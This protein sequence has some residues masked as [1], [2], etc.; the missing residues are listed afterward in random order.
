MVCFLLVRPIYTEIRLRIN[1]STPHVTD[2]IMRSCNL[3]TRCNLPY[4]EYGNRFSHASVSAK[5]N[6][7][8]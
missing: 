3:L 8:R 7:L 5:A 2:T 6:I 1:S 4:R